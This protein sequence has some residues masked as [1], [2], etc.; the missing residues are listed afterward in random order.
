MDKFTFLNYFSFMEYNSLLGGKNF[1]YPPKNTIKV[2]QINRFYK[3]GG[4]ELVRP[5]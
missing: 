5:L 4:L 1:Q 2:S 3:Y